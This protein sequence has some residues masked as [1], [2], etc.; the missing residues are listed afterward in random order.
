LF[1]NN[2]EA[3]TETLEFAYVSDAN[4]K[5]IGGAYD[6]QQITPDYEGFLYS[7]KIWQ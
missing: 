3:M 4:P 7:L 6:T 2:A 5:Y 1:V